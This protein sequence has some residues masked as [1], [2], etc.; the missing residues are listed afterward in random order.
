MTHPIHGGNVYKVA[1]EQ[2][3]PVG[4]ILDFSASINPLG[5]PTSGRRA[6][7]SALK[8][9]V[10]YPDP[11]CWS[12]RQA[13]AQQCAVDPDMILVGNGST[14]LIHLLPGALAITSA[15]VM[16]PTFEEYAHALTEAGSSVQY[17]HARHDEQFRP[18]LHETLRQL[19]GKRSRFDAV[20]LKAR[21]F[22]EFMC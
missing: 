20:F 9:I 14:E 2:R 22:T 11:D 13:L 4:R 16:G 8:Q 19:S 5:F 15:L 12:L 6:I 3:I 17:V 1:R 21:I 18:P 7:G 10:H